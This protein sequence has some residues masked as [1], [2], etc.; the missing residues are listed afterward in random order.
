MFDSRASSRVILWFWLVLNVI[1]SVM[2]L[3]SIFNSME[4]IEIE[5]VEKFLVFQVV[6]IVFLKFL[7]DY[8]ASI[9]K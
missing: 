2:I 4:R 1:H 3:F 6:K 8:R 5:V 9:I 7:F